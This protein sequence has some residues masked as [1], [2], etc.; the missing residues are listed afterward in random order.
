MGILHHVN[1]KDFRKTRQNNLDEKKFLYLEKREE[2]IKLQLQYVREE[3][4]HLKLKEQEKIAKK[5]SKIIVE[6]KVKVS[7]DWKSNW[8]EELYSKDIEIENQL[9]V[10]EK[11]EVPEHLKSNWRKELIEGMTTGGGEIQLSAS[12]IPLD[13]IDA[14]DPA[15]FTAANGGF[16]ATFPQDG[17]MGATI[18][19]NGTGSGNNGGFNLGKS[20]L[21]FNGTGYDLSGAGYEGLDNTRA[22]ILTPF[23]STR[24]TT[25]EITAIVGNGSNGGEAPGVGQDITLWYTDPNG[26]FPNSLIQALDDENFQEIIAVPYNGSGSVRTYSVTIPS[27]LRKSGISF[28]LRQPQGSNPSLTGDN[29]GITEIKLKRTTPVSVMAPLDTPEA[30]SFFRVGP[31]PNSPNYETPEQRYRRVMQQM[32]ASQSYTNQK[33]GS[34]YPGSNFSGIRGVSASPLGRDGMLSAWGSDIVPAGAWGDYFPSGTF[35]RNS[36][37]VP[38][39]AWGDYFPSGTFGRADIG[40][41]MAQRSTL[42]PNKGIGSGMS[43]SATPASGTDDYYYK[44]GGGDYSLQLFQK[45]GHNKTRQ[46]IIDRGRKLLA[47][48]QKDIGS[49][50][51]KTTVFKSSGSSGPLSAV[52]AASLAAAASKAATPKPVPKPISLKGTDLQGRSLKAGPQTPTPPGYK[53]T[54]KPGPLTGKDIPRTSTQASKPSLGFKIDEPLNSPKTRIIGPASPSKSAAAAPKPSLNLTSKQ[55]SNIKSATTQLKS[56]V[57]N[58]LNLGKTGTI[59]AL[60]QLQGST[61]QSGAAYN[62]QQQARAQATA[63]YAAKTGQFGK[64][65]APAP[66]PKP[67]APKPAASKPTTTARRK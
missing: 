62:A 32:L 17:L 27:Y 57:G 65:A 41:G 28:V 56:Q 33:F 10:E 58:L 24:A 14:S 53:G 26:D 7:E 12:D 23:D 49:Q 43:G 1:G 36:G 50:K 35:G 30:V 66:A 11:I 31:T 34:N 52:K 15:S 29:Y 46:D 40:S 20:Y 54:F 39:G 47:S 42:S 2:Q 8:R 59:A 60:T 64:Y 9:V 45:Q 61:P 19:S 44:L 4:Q 55:Q 51:Q 22:V 25:L 67:A 3:I 37:I 5:S 63:N 38:D 21:S 18:V 6:N 16:D 13:T 48:N